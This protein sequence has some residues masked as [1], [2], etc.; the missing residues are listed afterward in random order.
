MQPLKSTWIVARIALAAIAV[1]LS[2]CG[3]AGDAGPE[4]PRNLLVICVDT[5]RADH[6][7]AYGDRPSRTP[8]IDEL[9]RTGVVFERAISHASWTL[10][11]FA[12]V[13]TSLYTSTHGCWNFDSRLGEGF[14]TLPEILSD[15]GFATAGVASHVFFNEKYGLQQGFDE[16]DDELAKRRADTGWIPITSPSVTEKALRW[17]DEQAAEPDERWMLWLHYFDPHY[18]YVPHDETGG[19]AAVEQEL[20]RRE[21]AYTDGYI[22]QVLAALEAKG[23]G[24]DTAILFLSDHGEAWEEHPGVR[25]HAKS[26]HKE[27]LRVP[28]ILRVPGLRARRVSQVVRTVDVLPTLLEV[29]GVQPERE[30]PFEG[31]SLVPALLGETVELPALLSEIRLHDGFT[32]NSIV[33]GRWKL[34]DDVSSRRRLLY[35]IDAD[36]EEQHDLAAEHPQV[37]EDLALKLAKLLERAAT[38]GEFYGDGGTVELSEAELEN[39]RALGYIDDE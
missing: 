29:L 10:P 33:E 24:D 6:L 11:S 39:L 36:F 37:V 21:I 30:Q 25:R 34:I 12:A 14:V 22:G 19:P 38:L 7:G 2:A 31:R 13:L 18:P 26:L 17:L 23:F 8:A 28:L 27:E 15:A 20:Y 9:A 3:S 4:R 5:L 35:D 16:F 1:G 32:A